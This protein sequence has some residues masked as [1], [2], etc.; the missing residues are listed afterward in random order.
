MIQAIF[1]FLFCNSLCSS[2][3]KL[4]NY[5]KLYNLIKYD[6]PFCDITRVAD[7]LYMRIKIYNKN[8]VK[9]LYPTAS[10]R[11]YCLR[12]ILMLSLHPIFFIESILYT[13][14]IG[15]KYLYLKW[16]IECWNWKIISSPT[17][18]MVYLEST[19]VLIEKYVFTL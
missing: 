5:K 11:F 6:F 17:D 15:K 1:A 16:E 7:S 3:N 14:N 8:V 4:N 13:S 12:N 18:E 19:D 9:L 10:Q 2:F